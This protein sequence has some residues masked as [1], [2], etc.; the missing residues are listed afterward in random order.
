MRSR[1][2]SPLLSPFLGGYR[3][4]EPRARLSSPVARVLPIV[5]GLGRNAAMRPWHNFYLPTKDGR[6]FVRDNI[7]QPTSFLLPL[8]FSL[9]ESQNCLEFEI[10]RK[11]SLGDT[12][13]RQD[14]LSLSLFFSSRKRGKRREEEIR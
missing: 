4:R 5:I 6:R 3:S 10:W 12:W 7:Y 13:P 11:S 8:S 14:S 1:D 2:S 9:I